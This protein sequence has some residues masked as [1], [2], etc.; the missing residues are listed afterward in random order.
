LIKRANFVAGNTTRVSRGG[1]W[2]CEFQ[3]QA[4]PHQDEKLT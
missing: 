1:A 3:S 2:L 4:R